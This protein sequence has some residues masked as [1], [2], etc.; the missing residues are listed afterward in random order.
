MGNYITLQGFKNILLIDYCL[1]DEDIFSCLK[2]FP[3]HFPC[4]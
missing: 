2:D 1:V 3:I 4:K